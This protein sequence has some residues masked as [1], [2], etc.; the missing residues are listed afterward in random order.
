M[1]IR[2]LAALVAALLLAPAAL[3]D[4][5]SAPLPETRVVLGYAATYEGSSGNCTH[6]GVDLAAEAGEG[7]RSVGDGTVKFAGRVPGSDGGQ[8]YAVTIALADG[9]QATLMPL[10]SLSVATGD[11]VSS[12]QRL[13]DLAESGDRSYAE[14]HLHLGATRNGARLDPMTLLAATPPASQQSE[15][16]A[17]PAI[18]TAPK[19][20]AATVSSAKASAARITHQTASAAT[21]ASLRTNV[22]AQSSALAAHAANIAPAAHVALHD[23]LQAPNVAGGV[24]ADGFLSLAARLAL[25]EERATPTS[26]LRDVARVRRLRTAATRIGLGVLAAATSLFGGIAVARRRLATASLEPAPVLAEDRRGA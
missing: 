18:V 26:A 4:G 25:A 17:E 22:P 15:P 6:S 9:T 19:A 24:A 21:A 7:V 23:A 5:W 1:R 14:P 2:F 16:E 11:A 20:A 13:G 8:V 3:A 10:A 12:G